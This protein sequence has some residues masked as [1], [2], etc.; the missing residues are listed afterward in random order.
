MEEIV[1]TSICTDT[2]Q[3]DKQLVG[4][5]HVP[6]EDKKQNEEIILLNGKLDEK[7]ENEDIS[8][9][10]EDSSSQFE[11]KACIIPELESKYLEEQANL[12]K[13]LEESET[14]CSQLQKVLLQKDEFIVC[15]EKGKHL[16]DKEKKMLKREMELAVK[17]KENAVMRYCTVEK[18]VLDMK[19]LKETF[20]RK[21]KEANKEMELMNGKIKMMGTEKTRICNMLDAKCHE[22]KNSQ[23]ECE[24]IKNDLSSLEMKSKWNLLKIKQ[25]TDLRVVAEKK[26]EELNQEL[27]LFKSNENAKIKEETQIEK[28]SGKFVKDFF[29]VKN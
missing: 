13:L 28:L 21:F 24:K 7:Q 16:L 2:G 12:K 27:N 26:I 25:E 17:E 14:K 11:V 9:N 29:F 10:S 19:T 23:K 3:V 20:E 8:Y 1:E 5:T 6:E 22:L 15:Q 4:N 18:G